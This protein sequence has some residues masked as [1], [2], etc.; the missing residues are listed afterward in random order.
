MRISNPLLFTENHRFVVYRDFSF[1]PLEQKMLSCVY[2]PLVGAAAA[3]FYHLLCRQLPADRVGC[4]ALD[5]QRK[6][7]LN[8]GLE[9]N[10]SGRRRLADYCSRLEAVGLLGS[11]CVELPDAEEIVYEYRLYAPLKPADFFQT[12][13]L[14]MLL[15]DK[16]GRYAV[17]ALAEELESPV[18]EELNDPYA[19]RKDLSVPFYEMFLLNAKEN[20]PAPK[21]P[22]V[23]P[24][25]GL[26][27]EAGTA[28]APGRFRHEDI[29]SRFPRHSVNRRWVERLGERGE[30]LAVVNYIADKYGLTL[31]E[32]CQLLDEDDVFGIAGE[33][34]AVRLEDRAHAMFMQ[35]VKREE[36]RDWALIGQ[37]FQAQAE[38]AAG[39]E[40]SLPEGPWFEVPEWLAGKYDKTGY[41]RMLATQP[42]TRALRALI[43]ENVSQ[44]TLKLFS[45]LNLYYQLPD[46]VLNAL[47]HHMRVMNKPWKENYIEKV[48]AGLQGQ[49]IRT[50]GQAVAYFL[51]EQE[52]ARALEEGKAGDRVPGAGRQRLRPGRKPK[53][54]IHDSEGFSEPLTPEEEA[55]LERILRRLERPADHLQAEGGGTGGVAR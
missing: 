13:H 20:E 24:S 34:S 52:A 17:R 30:D 14:A 41:N 27:Q 15:R 1:G 23:P 16:L 40:E 10:E 51:K 19:I 22:V 47:I 9:M 3:A 44:A 29:L 38:T 4:S 8:L 36:E 32:I 50:Y 46:P 48:A 39:G 49:G 53:L 18:P 43:A 12:P 37:A 42:F 5:Q 2:Q 11:G 33:L 54:P 25:Y 26:G 6:L 45:K 28:G 31:K 55:E 21:E 7:F 35:N